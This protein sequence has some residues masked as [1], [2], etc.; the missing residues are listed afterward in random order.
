MEVTSTA[1]VKINTPRAE[2]LPGG[3]AR[4]GQMQFLLWRSKIHL[5]SLPKRCMV[6]SAR[7]HVRRQFG[8]EA[9]YR[10]ELSSV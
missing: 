1:Q 6:R 8:V 4:G 7:E 2:S 3:V 9:F 10:S 5:I